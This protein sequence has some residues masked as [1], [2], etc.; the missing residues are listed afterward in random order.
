MIKRSRFITWITFFSLAVT[1]C[2]GILISGRAKAQAGSPPQRPPG[3][4]QAAE[5]SRARYPQLARYATELTA[6]AAAARDRLS[7]SE[8]DPAQLR[9]L[10]HILSRDAQNNPALL[11]ATGGTDAQALTLALVQQIA[12]GKA[13][14]KLRAKRIFS[15]DL[16]SLLAGA[17]DGDEVAARLQMVIA[18]TAGAHGQ[19]VLFIPELPALVGANAAHG[20]Q[21]A[22]LLTDALTRG[23]L[24]IIAATTPAAFEH[25]IATDEAL[26]T[27]FA[28]VRL[29]ETASESDEETAGD[30]QSFTGERVST[31]LLE[32]A[33]QSGDSRMNVILQAGDV[34]DARL[35]SFLKAHGARVT[36]RM[37]QLGMLRVELTARA[38]EELATNRQVQFASLDKEVQALG[39][40]TSTTGADAVRG[41]SS[42]WKKYTLDGTGVGIAVLD[43]SIFTSHSSFLGKD[44]NKR[45][46]ADVDFT[47]TGMDTDDPYGHGT[48]VA[49]TAAGN[50]I[51]SNGAYTGIAS[52]SKLINLRVLDSRGVGS[53]TKLLQALEWVIANRTTY[54]I[55]VVN[56][57]L[58]TPAIDSYKNDP[59]CRAV[60]RLADAG[61]VVVAAA[62][63]DGK[64]T[65]DQKVY[66]QIHSP[67]NEP[68]AITV[69]ASN[70]FGTDVRSN[71]RV[72]SFSSRGPTRSFWKD[73]LASSIT[74]TSLSPTSSP[75]AIS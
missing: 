71:D 22:S 63:N 39:H 53:V 61:V 30:E 65:A 9:R 13:P 41:S 72:A 62:G 38:V 69:G 44:G 58:G 23:D 56:M 59:L 21:V 28:E 16:T 57:S 68:S 29:D 11:D 42:D 43:S 8:H 35:K 67:G 64:N 48:H 7:F 19:V 33:Q 18:E 75:P 3:A 66:G 54:N 26:T 37:S 45:I 51:V 70:T 60:R 4:R 24:Q 5:G 55:R 20:Q 34:N 74:I 52:N 46:V 27:L 6:A 14:A 50:G 25:N 73:A 40:V 2:D 1:L 12:V 10:A 15:L 36:S 17:K 31:E 47:G 49:S 32:L